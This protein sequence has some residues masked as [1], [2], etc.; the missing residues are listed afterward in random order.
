[1]S[2]VA[3]VCSRIGEIWMWSPTDGNLLGICV[4]ATLFSARD[5]QVQSFDHLTSSYLK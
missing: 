1:M 5:I 2:W 4:G 3:Q